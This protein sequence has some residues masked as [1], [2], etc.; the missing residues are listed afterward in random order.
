M[1]TEKIVPESILHLPVTASTVMM[2]RAKTGTPDADFA[3]S[4][5]HG[6][7]V[8]NG[9]DVIHLALDCIG[10]LLDIPPEGIF[11]AVKGPAVIYGDKEKKIIKA[12]KFFTDGEDWVFI[13]VSYDQ[14]VPFEEKSAPTVH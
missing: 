6:R 2:G 9:L 12:C 8:E 11:T 14:V 1:E 13:C 7:Q 3:C 10:E 4:F 5:I